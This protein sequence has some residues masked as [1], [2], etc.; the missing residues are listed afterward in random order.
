[1]KKTYLDTHTHGQS[2]KI[3]LAFQCNGL[4]AKQLVCERSAVAKL[5]CGCRGQGKWA[6]SWRARWWA[7]RTRWLSSAECHLGQYAG[8][9]RAP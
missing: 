3:G 1:M 5:P 8:F 7:M 4:W 2:V 9:D 6:R